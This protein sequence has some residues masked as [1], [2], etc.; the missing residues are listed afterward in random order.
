MFHSAIPVRASAFAVLMLLLTAMASFATSAAAA[1]KCEAAA[2]VQSA[3]Q[4]FDRAASA[5][6]A[7]AFTSA[8]SRYADL[9]SLSLFALGRYRS[10]LPKSREQEYVALTRNFIGGFMLRYGKGFRASTL[11]IVDCKRSGKQQVVT[12]QLSTGG[13][14]I[15]RVSGSGGRYSIS[16][17]NMSGVWLAQQMRSTFVGTIRRSGSIDGLFSYL[18][19]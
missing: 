4:A 2:Y 3:G 15:F 10:E 17:V 1:P 19:S 6:S 5:G 13:K 18:K 7:S 9:R 8:A 16:D 14:V 11:K 12:A